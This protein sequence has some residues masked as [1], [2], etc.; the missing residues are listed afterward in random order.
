MDL[1][2]TTLILN[3]FRLAFPNFELTENAIK[4][5]HELF[6]SEAPDI[7]NMALLMAVKEP[8]RAFFPS[9][10]E[11][12]A[13]ILK[14]LPSVLTMTASEALD[15]LGTHPLIREAE[16]FSDRCNYHDPRTQYSSPEELAQANRINEAIWKR[17]FKEHFLVLQ[18]RVKAEVIKGV[19]M[20][21]AVDKTLGYNKELPLPVQGLID[22][23]IK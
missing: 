6:Y 21:E 14:S 7:F 9:P 4:L 23:I 1:R 8:G 2:Q 12:Q 13:Y 20:D 10:G 19:S 22:S 11:V 5:W 16:R 15:N 3:K 18:G 17:D